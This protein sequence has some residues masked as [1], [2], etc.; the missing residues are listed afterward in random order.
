MA[1]IRLII[2]EV[3]KCPKYCPL[4]YKLIL[5]FLF[6]PDSIFFLYFLINSLNQYCQNNSKIIKK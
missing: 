1:Q 6:F 5:G 4:F 2:L 3:L